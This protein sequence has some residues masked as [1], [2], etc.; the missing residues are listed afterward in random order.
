MKYNGTQKIICFYDDPDAGGFSGCKK[1][2][3][4]E[5]TP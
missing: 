4:W 1:S 3:P 2:T 5:Q